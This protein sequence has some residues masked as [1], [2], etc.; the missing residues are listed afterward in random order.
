MPLGKSFELT[1]KLEK[2][3]ISGISPFLQVPDNCMVNFASFV[4]RTLVLSENH[5]S[6]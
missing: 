6:K 3:G 4:N 2:G 5:F 1:E